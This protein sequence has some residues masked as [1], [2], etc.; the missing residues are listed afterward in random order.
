MKYAIIDYRTSEEEICNLKKLGC[1]VLVCPQSPILYEAVCGHPD[2]LLHIINQKNIVVHKDMNN[3]FINLLKN[4]GL[5]VTFSENSLGSTYPYDIILN[6]VNLPNLFIH[7]IKYT[8]PKLLEM[9]NVKKLIN[10]KQGYAKCSTAIVSQNAAMTSDTT[11]AKSLSKEN[12]DVLLLPPGDIL[13]PGLN[14]GFIGGC[15]GLLDKN[16]LAF[17]GDLNYYAY[18]KEVSYFLKKHNIEPIFLR[19][20]KLIDRGSLFVIET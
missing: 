20:H 13:L 4:L 7:N 15:C 12:I 11:I 5:S 8:D 10:V 9:V 2:M 19:K 3:G 14:Y 16:L 6:S 17:Y 18:G 1:D